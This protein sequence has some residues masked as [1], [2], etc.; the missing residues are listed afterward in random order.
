[1]KNNLNTKIMKKIA[2]LSVITLMFASCGS[3]STEETTGVDS[4]SVAVQIDTVIDGSCIVAD[5]LN[6]DSVL[7][8]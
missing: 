6:Q 3:N 2:L 8:N 4:T 1:M 7:V 5:S